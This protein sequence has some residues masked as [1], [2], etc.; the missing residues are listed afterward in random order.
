M[1]ISLPPAFTSAVPTARSAPVQPPT[2]PIPPTATPTPAP[3]KDEAPL[4]IPVQVL[5]PAG[6]AALK[7]QRQELS[8]QLISAQGRRDEAARALNSAT[9]EAARAGIEQRLVVLDNRI[10]QLERDIAT[11][12]QQLALG[13]P[14][15]ANESVGARIGPFSSGQLTGISIVSIVLVWAPLAFALARIMLKRWGAPKPAPQILESA[16]RLERLEQAVDAVAI[17]IERIS[18][19]QRYV[20]QLMTKQQAPVLHVGQAPAEPLTVIDTK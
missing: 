19:G 15:D 11:T 17:E 9:T 18:E 10:V 4:Q 12:G 7:A 3:A 16:A 20:T 1:V 6:I 5:S 8:S 2:P 13:Q 14:G